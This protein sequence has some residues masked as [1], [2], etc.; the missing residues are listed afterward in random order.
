MNQSVFTPEEVKKGL[1]TDL[2]NYLI[3]HN[4]KS[5]KSY[6]EIKVSTDGYCTIV[7]WVEISY[8]M[9]GDCGR[10]EY[11]EPDQV[12]MREIIF[13]DNHTET[14]HDE[15]IQ[16]AVEEFFNENT[17]LADKYYYQPSTKSFMRK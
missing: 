16:E 8:D 14:L 15:D 4:A 11:L 12:V 13:P 3:G 6:N 17:D 2:I 7:D 9:E 5:D 1:F 10:F